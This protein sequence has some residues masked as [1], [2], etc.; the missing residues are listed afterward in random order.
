MRATLLMATVFLVACAE[1]EPL[2]EPPPA[3]P[4]AE[5]ALAIGGTELPERETIEMNGKLGILPAGRATFTFAR[6]GD[7]YRSVSELRTTGLASL[8]YGVDIVAEATANT[9]DARSRR[10]T[11]STGDGRDENR[12]KRVDIVFGP[13]RGRIRSVTTTAEGVKEVTRKDPLARDPFA[14]VYALRQASLTPGFAVGGSVFTE[15]FLYRAEIAVVGE[16]RVE[17]PAGE[18]ETTFVRVDLRKV[19]DGIPEETTRGMAVWLTRDNRRIPVRIALDTERGRVTLSMTAY[20]QGTR[21]ED[22]GR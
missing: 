18:F 8:L 2:P 4:A 10:F 13:E 17:V 15:W 3:P 19:V 5:D 6:E 16:E 11:W 9:G 20:R 12:D 1:F 22:A 7:V 14:M 21:Q